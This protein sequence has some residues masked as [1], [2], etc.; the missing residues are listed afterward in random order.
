MR[1]EIR[2]VRNQR[3]PVGLGRF[4]FLLLRALAVRP[5]HLALKSV[6]CWLLAARGTEAAR[7]RSL[8]A[9][10]DRR[11]RIPAR[12]LL[13]NQIPSQKQREYRELRDSDESAKINSPAEP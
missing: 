12:T 13:D 6:A 10:V 4:Q 3:P 2:R 5:L 8:R 11:L 7:W 9:A 1:C